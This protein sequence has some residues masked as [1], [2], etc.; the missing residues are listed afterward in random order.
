MALRPGGSIRPGMMPLS[1]I[2]SL[3]SGT[4]QGWG[5]WT[6]TGQ[7]AVPPVL[8]S[9]MAVDGLLLAFLQLPQAGGQV[10]I[11]PQLWGLRTQK[12]PRAAASLLEWLILS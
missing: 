8:S 6:S 2:V 4:G 1:K 5:W 12:T 7:W 11:S 3:V 9:S 10:Q